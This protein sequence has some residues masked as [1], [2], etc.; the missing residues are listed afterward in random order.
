MTYTSLPGASLLL[1]VLMAGTP[2]HAQ[3]MYRCGSAYQD[4][5][6]EGA[7][8]GSE[9]RN[10]AGPAPSPSAEPGTDSSCRQ[11][12]IDSQ[13]I[14][15]S[16]EAGATAERQLADVSAH[17]GNSSQAEDQRS[18]IT[19]VYQKRGSAPQVR[20]A[21]EADCVADKKRA[22]LALEAAIALKQN[23]R[24]RTTT[25]TLPSAAADTLSQSPTGKQSEESARFAAERQE[26]L[27][28][29][30]NADLQN[31]RDRQRSGGSASTM[32]AL[33]QQ[34]RNAESEKTRG[35][36]R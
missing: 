6:C 3:R 21:I 17:G 13:K 12:G 35:N 23:S 31:I 4:R 24:D 28:N 26:S 30:V 29:R 2:V 27:C 33:R 20:A 10:F 7:Q 1:L 19:A 25:N 34:Q 22:E 11:R 8:G 9:V 14:V 15:W 36:C 18:L 32:E 16:R 5:P